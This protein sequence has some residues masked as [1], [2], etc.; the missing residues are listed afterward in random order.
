MTRPPTDSELCQSLQDLQQEEAWGSVVAD[1]KVETGDDPFNDP[2]IWV[3]VILENMQEFE[4]LGF[5]QRDK[6]RRRVLETIDKTDETRWVYVQFS[7]REEEELGDEPEEEKHQQAQ[8][9]SS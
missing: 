5:E 2:A 8:K 4:R 9:V 7:T 6:I 1:W 3:W